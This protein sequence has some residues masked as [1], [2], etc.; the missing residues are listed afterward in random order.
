M[1]NGAWGAGVE[2]ETVSMRRGRP[3]RAMEDLQ[4]CAKADLVRLIK[5]TQ[6]QKIVGPL[7]TWSEYVKVSNAAAGEKAAR[8]RARPGA[9][10]RAPGSGHGVCKGHALR[11]ERC[12]SPS[13]QPGPS[14][15]AWAPCSSALGSQSSSRPPCSL[16]TLQ[17]KLPHLKSFD[18]DRHA[19]EVSPHAL[20]TL[21]PHMHAGMHLAC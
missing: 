20:S 1:Q 7:G 2:G 12:C 5:A 14:T 4:Q 11:R 18:P 8:P 15:P 21:P 19:R 16:C 10:H 9:S 3:F 13:L 17:E 6:K